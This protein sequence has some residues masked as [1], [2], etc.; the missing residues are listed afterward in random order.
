MKHTKSTKNRIRK[1][2]QHRNGGA[3]NPNWR[4]GYGIDKQ[5]YVR[6]NRTLAQELYPDATL[7]NGP[8]LQI[9]RVVMSHHLKRPLY[10]D[11][12]V[13]HKNGIKTDYSIDN[14][15]LRARYHGKGQSVD[16]LRAWAIEILR[17]YATSS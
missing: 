7:G 1:T 17:R 5:G 13:H 12:S 4:G 15:E 10:K 14:L 11:E 8:Q 16:D 2:L 6:I 3:G 9:H